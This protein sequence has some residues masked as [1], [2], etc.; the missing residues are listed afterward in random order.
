MSHVSLPSTSA[1]MDNRSLFESYLIQYNSFINGPSKHLALLVEKEINRLG[2]VPKRYDINGNAHRQTFQ[3]YL[4]N[5]HNHNP[6][7]TINELVDRMQSQGLNPFSVK[8]NNSLFHVT[9]GQAQFRKNLPQRSLF[10]SL[11]TRELGLQIPVHQ[12][13]SADYFENGLQRHSR[14]TGHIDRTYTVH[15]D[16]TGRYALTAADDCIV[17]VWDVNTAL[18]RYTF[19]GHMSLISDMSISY[20][21]QF[22]ASGGADKYVRVWSLQNGACVEA[23]HHH[24]AL[25][26]G[27]RFLPYVYKSVRFLFSIGYDCNVIFYEFNADTRE[28]KS[29]P[30]IFNVRDASGQR[31]LSS[32][33]SP[34]G[35]FVA[36][37]DSQGCLRLFCIEEANIS[38]L[39]VINAIPHNERLD[40]LEWCHDGMAFVSSSSR[41]HIAR[42]WRFTGGEWK[43]LNLEPK[44]PDADSLALFASTKLKYTFT[45]ICWSLDDR[46][47]ISSGSDHKLRVYD[48]YTGIEKHRLNGHRGEAFHL[49]THPLHPN[50]LISSAHDGLLLIWDIVKGQLLKK[51]TS[52]TPEGT[53]TIASILDVAVNPEGTRIATV[54]DVGRITIYALGTNDSHLAPR[55]QFFHTDYDELDYDEHGYAL[56]VMSGMAPHLQRP[57]LIMSLDRDTLDAKWQ[58]RVPGKE[59]DLENMRCA[60]LDRDIIPKL[61]QG[62]SDFWAS[63]MLELYAQ[64]THLLESVQEEKKFSNYK[65]E[66]VDVTV[67]QNNMGRKAAQSRRAIPSLDAVIAAQ[68]AARA[69][70]S[71]QGYRSE[72]DDD[73]SAHGFSE[74]ESEASSDTSDSDYDGG[75]Q[76]RREEPTQASP[77]ANDVVTSSGRRVQRRNLA[78]EESSSSGPTRVIARRRRGNGDESSSSEVDE[79]A[80]NDRTDEEPAEGPSVET[81]RKKRKRKEGFL[82]YFPESM[83]TV[84]VRRFPYIVQLGDNV[85]YC[86]QGHERYLEMVEQALLFPISTKMHPPTQL[87]AEEFCVVEDV[88]YTRKPYR[89]CVIRLAQTNP[90]G[91]LT[92]YRFTVK[93]HDLD[94]SPDFIILK[95]HYDASVRLNLRDGD[96]IESILDGQWWTGTVT[97]RQPHDEAFPTSH[98]YCLNIRWDNGEDDTISPWDCQKKTSGRRS[99]TEATPAEIISCGETVPTQGCWPGDDSPITNRDAFCQRMAEGIDKLSANEIVTPFSTPVNLADFPLYSNI[100]DYCIDMQTISERLRNKWYRRLISLQHDIR[101]IALAAEQ[102]NEPDSIIVQNSRILVETLIM[103]SND[104]SISADQLDTLFDSLFDLPFEQITEYKKWHKNN[105]DSELVQLATKMQNQEES[106]SQSRE[107]GWIG[108]ALVAM[109]FVMAHPCAA[110]FLSADQC[111]DLDVAS[112]LREN[113]DLQIIRQIIQNLPD[114]Q[115]V[116]EKVKELVDACQNAINDNRSRIYHSTVQLMHLTEEKMKPIITQFNQFL[117][118]YETISGRSLRRRQKKEKRSSYNT[119]RRNFENRSTTEGFYRELANGRIPRGAE[120]P[121]VRTRNSQRT[122]RSSRRGGS[123]IAYDEDDEDF[124][125]E[126]S[127]RGSRDR[128][129]RTAP[130]DDLVSHSFDNETADVDQSFVDD[131]E[132]E[133]HNEESSDSSSNSS[134]G[135]DEDMEENEKG[136]RRGEDSDEDEND[137][138]DDDDDDNADNGADSSNDD[139]DDDL[140]EEEQSSNNDENKHQASSSKR[141]RRESSDRESI[142]LSAKRRRVNTHADGDA[143]NNR[144]SYEDE[145]NGMMAE[146]VSQRDCQMNINT[147]TICHEIRNFSDFSNYQTVVGKVDDESNS[148]TDSTSLPCASPQDFSAEVTPTL[149]VP[150]SSWVNL[151]DQRN[152]LFVCMWRNCFHA[153]C[154]K[155][156]FAIHIATHFDYYCSDNRNSNHWPCQVVGCGSVMENASKFL[157]HLS[158]HKYHAISQFN[159][160]K[161]LINSQS[162]PVNSCGYTPNLNVG[163]IDELTFCSYDGC[164]LGFR[165]ICDF[166]NH[167]TVHIDFAESKERQNGKFV[168]KW[169]NCSKACGARKGDLRR[170][171]RYHSGEKYCACPYCG[172]FFGR[173]EKFYEHMKRNLPV[174]QKPFVCMLCQK[175]FPDETLLS[176]H[177]RRH[178]N[179]VQCRECGLALPASS[180]LEK[181]MVSKHSTRERSFACNE[182]SA[183]FFTEETLQKHKSIHLPP[184]LKCSYCGEMFRWKLQL[185]RHIAKHENLPEKNYLCHICDKKYSTGHHLTRHLISIH[186]C[187]IPEGFSRFYYKKCND[188]YHRLQTKKLMKKRE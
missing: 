67:L 128:R 39:R 157:A 74:D 44:L 120:S 166:F 150:F 185:T 137:D 87:A 79:A 22:M 31:C 139:E 29:T 26:T 154:G 165:D 156:E 111:S 64:E 129:R 20:C 97:R 103:F 180:D 11:S 148:L 5:N 170:H 1:L 47:V 114:P 107:P 106:S 82:Q 149:E 124:F 175:C 61:G 188:G 14:V 116:V 69:A 37:G 171:V 50:I 40:S 121:P 125:E 105:I 66:D 136:V 83:R 71:L 123:N 177:V 49:R 92:G 54:D 113:G 96:E 21:N 181:H 68:D 24:S 58:R 140:D 77:Q 2:L 98:W 164:G 115:S 155:E 133:E 147:L 45:M 163:V 146:S 161:N 75:D 134:S 168:C 94:N 56:D 138:D 9:R 23:F 160:M 65:P 187:P 19:R 3:Q 101:F 8:S 174:D 130:M 59:K 25:I 89:L 70:N 182:C 53:F 127:S 151:D 13:Y 143:E 126:E 12:V 90:N 153:L 102:F 152:I 52:D 48:A 73:Y 118:T 30:T 41:Y 159:G 84:T 28:F 108:D 167:V 91:D 16:Q 141:N 135:S 42:V 55:E 38:L 86:K 43:Y 36:V 179:V 18:L 81:P 27:I 60:W 119:R 51:F 104:R 142:P 132:K 7:T 99:N 176:H 95:A 85:V 78:N 76:P 72:E 110:H 34:S 35:K 33:F 184:Q 93:M 172:S 169:N 100:V 109:D 32:T 186:S 183:T 88:R 62:P 46:Y 178:I 162:L 63:K 80:D 6:K 112:A 145:G 17:K 131:E 144:K 10:N 117:L 158:M 173:P 57:P 4:A 122:T 15:F